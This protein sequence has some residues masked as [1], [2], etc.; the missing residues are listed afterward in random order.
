MRYGIDL[1]GTKI[2]IVAL[3]AGGHEAYR[4]RVATPAG[5]YLGTLQAMV[6]LVKR[7]RAA[8]GEQGSVGVGTPGAISKVTGRLKNSNSV[9]LNGQRVKEDLEAMLGHEIRMANDANC[10]ALSEAVDGAGKGADVVFGAILGTGCGAGVVVHGRVLNG[11]N[12][13]A[14]EW[15]HNP[16]PFLHDDDLPLPACYC[17]QRGC[18]ETYLAGTGLAR[19]HAQV[20]GQPIKGAE[21]VARAEAGDAACEATLVRYEKRLA[22]SLA[23]VI[24]MLDPDVIVL[25]GGA[26]NIA[27]LYSN[28]PKYWSNYVFGGEVATRLLP[29]VH[30]D[31]GGVRGAAWLW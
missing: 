18:V 5:D 20:T 27:R 26:S 31:S 21:I 29:N 19:D 30:G 25:G 24:N 6:G 16:L 2:E 23:G 14:G 12:S 9:V 3:G 10:F 22:R 7:A 28:V 8:T 17:G 13:I 4:E 11:L 15:G 1:G